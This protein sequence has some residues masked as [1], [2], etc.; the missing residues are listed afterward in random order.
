MQSDNLQVNSKARKIVPLATFLPQNLFEEKREASTSVRGREY[1]DQVILQDDLERAASVATLGFNQE[2]ERPLGGTF[3]NE[4]S[5]TEWAL[6][7]T[8]VVVAPLASQCMIWESP[9]FFTFYRDLKRSALV[10]RSLCQSKP[11]LS[12]ARAGIEIYPG[13]QETA[14][15]YWL[16]KS[17]A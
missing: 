11:Y 9:T 1:Y 5:P 8:V 12:K 14:T 6:N 13:S 2:L 17:L 16:C 7:R 15:V 10:E 3:P 4:D